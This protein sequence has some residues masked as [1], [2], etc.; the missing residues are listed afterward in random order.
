MNNWDLAEILEIQ[1]EIEEFLLKMYEAKTKE[2]YELY[3]QM[4][5]VNIDAIKSLMQ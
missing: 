5:M 2:D 3:K 4:I 1:K